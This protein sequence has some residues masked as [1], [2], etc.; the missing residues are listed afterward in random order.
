MLEKAFL[1]RF[2][3]P[4]EIQKKAIPLILSGKN[5]LIVAP[6]GAGK[7]EA[8]VLPVFEQIAIQKKQP[9]S[10]LYITPLR[11]LN[12]D[13]EERL[14]YWGNAA[15]IRIEVRHG[16]TPAKIKTKQAKSPPHVL[17]TTP[18]TLQILL[19]LPQ[20]KDHLRNV[21]W[22]IVDE[23][24]ELV[25]SK[26]GS[27]LSLGLARLSEFAD[28][29][30]IGLSATLSS[31]K[32]AELIF[33]GKNYDVVSGGEKE[34]KAEVKPIYGDEKIKEFVRSLAEKQKIMIFVNTRSE[35]E[36]YGSL[37]S[38]FAFVHHGS[39]SREI[40]EEAERKFKKGELK[41]I[42]ATSSLE[43]GIDIGDVDLVVQIGSPRQ[44]SRFL[45]RMGRSGHSLR[46]VSRA[47]IIA[48]NEEER[49]ESEGIIKK[50]REGWI[51]EEKEYTSPLDV[52]A[53]QIVGLAFSKI[54]LTKVHEILK[55]SHIYTLSFEK[56]KIIAQFLEENNVIF[57]NEDGTIKATL[58]GKK[59]YFDNV[60]TIPK[61]IYFSVREAQ[62]GTIIGHVDEKFASQLSEGDSF[63][64]K[65]RP[66]QVASL[67]EE[68]KVI[69]LSSAALTVPVWKGEDLPVSKEV[70]QTVCKE[71][72]G[73]EK[74]D[75]LVYYSC[76]GTIANNAI[77]AGLKK[78]VEELTG[79]QA[80]GISDAY[81]IILKLPFPLGEHIH[82]IKKYNIRALAEKSIEESFIFSIKFT[83]VA[84]RF[85]ILKEDT[86]FNPRLAKFFKGSIV[87]EEAV[88][89]AKRYFD[90]NFDFV[91]DIK[92]VDRFSRP[93]PIE[94]LPE[95]ARIE[96]FKNAVESQDVKLIC[97]NCG[98]TRFTTILRVEEMP[99]CHR[100]GW[101][102]ALFSEK[103]D[104][105]EL[106]YR[107]NLTR[108]YGKKAIIALTVFGVG[109]KTADR[110]LR[111]LHKDEF[112]FWVDLIEAQKT[113]LKTRK[114]WEV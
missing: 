76:Q 98:A 77:L 27:Q 80:N 2:K 14:I 34:W 106:E 67:E 15:G 103:A 12:R 17:I 96:A 16:D 47:I 28:F 110:I 31:P 83:H 95:S 56:S 93:L 4:T 52:I 108:A 72:F 5:V 58:K 84:R 65:G 107:A 35:A 22:V 59:Y 20:F 10:A 29:K 54:P 100:C 23:I 112:G 36:L 13:M 92:I 74:E 69:P 25:D 26:R 104:K 81:R 89:E 87:Y 30:T 40:R 86:P 51:E 88:K 53:H 63:I 18:E 24:H 43:L 101:P 71:L 41:A 50:A 99:K 45:Q 64:L 113:F 102:L 8:A 49:K 21:G 38:D 75:I 3:E 48:R 78:A 82:K 105:E 33:N 111:R 60:S 46:Q 55:K 11:A 9:I 61:E 32:K 68:I 94:F 7:T 19:V 44:V 70:A 73:E 6:T 1:E 57:L 97:V 90:F 79:E 85:G 109:A 37:F 42:V 91:P 39:L 62:T 66:W 114:Y